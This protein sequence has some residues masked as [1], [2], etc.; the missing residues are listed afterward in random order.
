MT[1]DKFAL[2]KILQKVN[3]TQIIL[4]KVLYISRKKIELL[5]VFF[6]EDA[7]IVQ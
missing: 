7:R 6:R 3:I 2:I 1:F 4:E 5:L